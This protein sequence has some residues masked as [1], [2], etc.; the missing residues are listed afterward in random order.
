MAKKN[1]QLSFNNTAKL[2]ISVPRHRFGLLTE[3]LAGTAAYQSTAIGDS[4]DEFLIDFTA[5]NGTEIIRMVQKFTTGFGQPLPGDKPASGVS[6][7]VIVTADEWFTLCFEVP[8]KNTDRVDKKLMEM[9]S[10]FKLKMT[11]G[12]N[13]KYYVET[14]MANVSSIYNS[15]KA[16]VIPKN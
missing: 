5:A 6:I 2:F 14:W 9:A 12:E 4:H 3:A 15:V 10:S 8:P 16:L 7:A 1:K 11:E 13:A